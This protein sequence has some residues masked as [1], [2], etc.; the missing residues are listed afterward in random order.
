[1]QVLRS[2]SAAVEKIVL[3]S[4][5]YVVLPFCGVAVHPKGEVTP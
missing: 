2:C 5:S 4:C 1:M 3:G